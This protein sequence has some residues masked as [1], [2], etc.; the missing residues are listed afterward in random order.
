MEPAVVEP[1]DDSLKTVSLVS[2]VLHLIVAVSA[3]VP[4][5]QVGPVLLIVALMLDMVKKPDAEGT[6]QASHFKYRIRTVLWAAVGYTVTLPLWFVFVFP[7]WLA[8]TAIS[9]WFLYR[10][11]SGMMRWNRSEPMTE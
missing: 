11:V 6:W 7:G 3:V 5:A 2:Y 8:W 4:G 1:S 9:V 10:I